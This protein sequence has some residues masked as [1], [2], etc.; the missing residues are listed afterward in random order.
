MW[1]TI[2]CYFSEYGLDSDDDDSDLDMSDLV[3]HR[4][5]RS[6]MAS[7]INSSVMKRSLLDLDERKT[8]GKAYE[9]CIH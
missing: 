5:N 9:K 7:S 1:T 2:L 4:T 3:T 6:S 8:N